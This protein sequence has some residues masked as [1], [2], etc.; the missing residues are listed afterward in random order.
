MEANEKIHG[1][2]LAW[3]VANRIDSCPSDYG[4]FLFF[5]SHGLKVLGGV[6]G[7]RHLKRRGKQ[8]NLFRVYPQRR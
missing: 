1:E 2:G 5:L 4:P 8:D 7:V 6:V 3:R